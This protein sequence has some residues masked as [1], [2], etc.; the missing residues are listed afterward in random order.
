[1][2]DQDVTKSCPN[3]GPGTKVHKGEKGYTCETCGGT[4]TFVVGEPKLAV[5]GEL[6]RVKADVE[7]LKQRLPASTPMAASVAES[8][9]TEDT[10]DTEQD[11]DEDL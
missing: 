8:E 4:F 3:C 10:E 2:V 7:E 1:M 11:E 9:T 6:D 5:V